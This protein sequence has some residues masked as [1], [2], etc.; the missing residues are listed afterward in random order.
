MQLL[1]TKRRAKLFLRVITKPSIIIQSRKQQTTLYNG[2]TTNKTKLVRHNGKKRKNAESLI[3][4]NESTWRYRCESIP[5]NITSIEA[6][7]QAFFGEL[8]SFARHKALILYYHC[9]D[10]VSSLTT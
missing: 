7:Q 5:N 4:N 8:R 10:I 9:T 2:I 6:G 3:H 1:C